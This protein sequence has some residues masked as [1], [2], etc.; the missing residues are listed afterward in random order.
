MVSSCCLF[1]LLFPFQ[2]GKCSSGSCTRLGALLTRMGSLPPAP[3]PCHQRFQLALHPSFS[4][5]FASYC[6]SLEVFSVKQ[7]I[8]AAEHKHTVSC[9]VSMPLRIP[10]TFSDAGK[11][12]YLPG[13]GSAQLVFQAGDGHVDMCI[14]QDHGGASMI[15]WAHLKYRNLE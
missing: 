4:P 1:P 10:W 6:N 5:V 11:A 7:W 3:L 15:T 13:H 9:S 12:I 8:R 2:A 14:Q